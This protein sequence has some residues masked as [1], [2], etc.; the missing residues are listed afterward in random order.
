MNISVK[1]VTEALKNQGCPVFRGDWNLNLVGIRS[2]DIQ[3]NRFNDRLVVLFD[4]NG[5]RQLFW[6]EMTADPGTFYREN[7]INVE[8]TAV[9][10]PGHYAGCWM[11][12]AHRA[13]YPALVQIKPMAVYRDND[14][15]NTIDTDNAEIDSGLFGINLHHAK[16]NKF[17]TQVDKWS[18]GCQV[19]A[20]SFDFDL[21]MAL[22]NKSAQKYGPRFSYTLLDEK[23][24]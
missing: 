16:A 5:K 4:L 3:S 12:G 15:N 23:E 22:V 1:A 13:Q 9:L 14:Q 19:L 17:S 18:A 11:L 10:V 2:K 6:F 8:G 7:P 24:L 20:D 21:L